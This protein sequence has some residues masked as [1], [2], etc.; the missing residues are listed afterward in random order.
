MM[1]LVV[2][3]NVSCSAY[4]LSSRQGTTGCMQKSAEN[5]VKHQGCHH[6]LAV[7]YL[8]LE[9]RLRGVRIQA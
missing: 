2:S 1:I 8:L 7:R 5:T 9:K 4:L 6:F 3:V